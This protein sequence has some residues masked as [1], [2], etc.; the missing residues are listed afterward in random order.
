MARRVHG[1]TRRCDRG[2]PQTGQIVCYIT[3]TDLVLLTELMTALG[4]RVQC[5]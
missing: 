5:G 1:K 2:Q 3:Q 4:E